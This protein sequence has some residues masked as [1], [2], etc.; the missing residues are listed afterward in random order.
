[1]QQEKNGEEKDS[2]D[3]WITVIGEAMD[4]GLGTLNINKGVVN[5]PNKTTPG[6]N[7]SSSDDTIRRHALP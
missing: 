2:E 1:M 4:G 6:Y 7:L 3:P 5:T